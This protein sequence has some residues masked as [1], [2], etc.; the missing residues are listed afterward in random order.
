ML[1]DMHAHLDLYPDPI[2]VV[3]ECENRGVYVLSVTTTPK[4]WR[5]TSAL[6]NGKKRIKTGLG[7]HPQLAH[8]RAGELDLFDSFLHDAKYVGEIGLD[9]S[10]EFR[11]TWDV[12]LRV[13]RH[14]LQ[15]INAVGGR[16][17]SIHSRSSAAEVLP[18]L[19]GIHGIPVLHWFSG[20]KTDLDKAIKQGCWFSIGP[21]MLAS[22]KGQELTSMIPRNKIVTETDGPFGAI[23]GKVLMPWDVEIAVAQLAKI[24]SVD[25][26]EAKGVVASNFRQLVTHA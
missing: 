24:W 23:R 4:A 2:K 11:P 19:L 10:A 7:L 3:E 20:N 15:N 16:L 1:V 18:E 21:A 8:Q 26:V 6:A 22:K 9:G 12:Q 25:I 14:I 5:G 13:F 17:M